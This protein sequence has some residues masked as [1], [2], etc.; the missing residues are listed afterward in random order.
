MFKGG[1]FGTVALAAICGGFFAY[2]ASGFG[3]A[4]IYPELQS[5]SLPD[6]EGREHN[7]AEWKGKVLVINFWA[8]WCP[9]CL[10]EIPLF[11]EMQESHGRQGLQFIG[12][13]V[14]DP[15]PVREFSG[16]LKINYPILIAGLPG[17]GLS[18][19]LG[20]PAGVVPFSVVV[21]REG[22]IVHRHPGI[23]E[24]ARIQ[25]AVIPLL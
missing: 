2:Q 22:R 21:N 1:L 8:T 11:M 12:I 5:F 25:D 16:K 20:N 6:T 18:S 9:P 24:A 14:E 3:K 13:A 17:L 15:D 4:G 23:F 7:I 19:A 10:E